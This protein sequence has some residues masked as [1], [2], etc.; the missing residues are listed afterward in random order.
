[1]I[2]QENLV[3]IGRGKVASIVSDGVYAYKIYE[4]WMPIE[5]ILKEEKILKEIKAKTDLNV[6]DCEWLNDQ[7]MLKMTLIKGKTLAEMMRKEKYQFG[8]ETLIQCQ[9]QVFQYHDLQLEDAF[10][11]FRYTINTSSL[12]DDIKIKAL[13]SLSSIK[14]E[15]QLC[16]FDMHLEN[17]MMSSQ[18][19][20]IIDWANAKCG[21]PVMDIART[22]II[23]LQYVKRKANIYLKSIC[24]KMNYELNDVLNAIPIMAALRML[25]NDTTPFHHELLQLIMKDQT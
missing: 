19:P 20:F 4:P 11:S 12:S 1:M 22:Y 13:K 16:H 15:Q 2:N 9:I 24:K 21:N 14:F 6:I 23:M 8:I 25:E 3:S 17:I 18:T 7:N 5:H 10:V